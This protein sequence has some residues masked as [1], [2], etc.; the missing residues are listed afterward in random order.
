MRG[1]WGLQA[2]VSGSKN[3]TK[4]R[5]PKVH[6]EGQV[7]F[8]LALG[9]LTQRL[10]DSKRSLRWGGSYSMGSSGHTRERF[11]MGREMMWTGEG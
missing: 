9:F 3:V 6:T 7:G 11:K 5:I 10:G 1:L 4:E 8:G 2:P